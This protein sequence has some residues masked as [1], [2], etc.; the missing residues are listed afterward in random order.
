LPEWSR[1]PW[2]TLLPDATH[3]PTTRHDL[4]SATKSVTGLLFGIAH[5]RNLIPSLDKPVFEYFPEYADLRS[6]EKDRIL[7]R[8]I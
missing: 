3:G 7:L 2:W 8:E 6:P 1:R 4:R 5:D